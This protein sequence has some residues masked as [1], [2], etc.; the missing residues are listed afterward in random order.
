MNLAIDPDGNESYHIHCRKEEIERNGKGGLSWAR[1]DTVTAICATSA[2]VVAAVAAAVSA[3]AIAVSTASAAVIAAFADA[4]TVNRIALR[5]A[6]IGCGLFSLR[7]PRLSN[8]LDRRADG[9]ALSRRPLNPIITNPFA[10]CESPPAGQ[11]PTDRHFR[12]LFPFPDP[13][14]PGSIPVSPFAR[15]TLGQETG[16]SFSAVSVAPNADLFLLWERPD[17][18]TCRCFA[19]DKPKPQGLRFPGVKGRDPVRMPPVPKTAGY[20]PIR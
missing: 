10:G 18:R 6:G 14:S 8:P 19:R 20:P 9:R 11:P 15:R 2:A 13:A 16:I 3:V 4:E 7:D 12:N 5:P 17:Q 1:S